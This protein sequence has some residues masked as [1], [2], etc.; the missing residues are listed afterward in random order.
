M[1]KILLVDDDELLRS[2]LKDVLEEMGHRCSGA[3]NVFQAREILAKE[4]FDI[5]LSD[6][7]MPGET[8]LDLLIHVK[9]SYPHTAFIMMTASALPHMQK[10]ALDMGADG[11]LNKPFPMKLLQG[12]IER[13]LKKKRTR[14]RRVCFRKV[15]ET[16][17]FLHHSFQFHL[18]GERIKT[19]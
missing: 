19:A 10:K 1:A 16:L 11:Y 13:A 17:N 14:S 12:I 8:G 4:R 2:L 6:F 9:K 3:G 15:P 18:A 5:V 7:N